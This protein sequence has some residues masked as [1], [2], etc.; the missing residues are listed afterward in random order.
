[1]K[2]LTFFCEKK[3]KFNVDKKYF[4]KLKVLRQSLTEKN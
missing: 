1:M 3:I 4:A 2:Q